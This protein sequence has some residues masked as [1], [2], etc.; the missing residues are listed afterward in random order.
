MR[1]PIRK[2]IRTRAALALLFVASALAAQPA[3]A[4]TL[5][6]TWQVTTAGPRGGSLTQTFTL[7][8]DGSSLTGTVAITGGG[9]RGGG[10]GGG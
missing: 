2:S 3:S 5:T 7:T 9:R 6:G 1:N 8:Q 4:Q 10:G